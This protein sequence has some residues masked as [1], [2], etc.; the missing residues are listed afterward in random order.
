M[1]LHADDHDA[2]AEPVGADRGDGDDCGQVD[3]GGIRNG[4][5]ARNRVD[6]VEGTI[7]HG[8]TATLHRSRIC[9]MAA[10][11]ESLRL[12]SACMRLLI[13]ICPAVVARCS[14]LQ[15]CDAVTSTAAKYNPFPVVRDAVRAA[16]CR[17]ASTS[18]SKPSG[19]TATT[20]LPLARTDPA[21]RGQPGDAPDYWVSPRPSS[22][23]RL[24]SNSRVCATRAASVRARGPHIVVDLSM[25][26][27]DRL[28]GLRTRATTPAGTRPCWSTK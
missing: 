2:H 21:G 14:C 18:G 9:V 13:A 4:S 20:K 12:C 19:V 6:A 5:T 27:H 3:H 16:A 10:A 22:G 11:P 25:T 8:R 23:R 17:R 26:P 28:R 1:P 15:A 24:H 7:R